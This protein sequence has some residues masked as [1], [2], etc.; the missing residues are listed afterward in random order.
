MRPTRPDAVE[1]VAIF[2]APGFEDFMR[3]T[4]A[5]EG[6]QNIPLSQAEE[7]AVEKKHSHAVI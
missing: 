1:V 7:D 4:S 5:R 6:E 2:S 3:D